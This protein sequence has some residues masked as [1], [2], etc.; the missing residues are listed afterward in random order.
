[1]YEQYNPQE[2]STYANNK[3]A[4]DSISKRYMKIYSQILDKNLSED[5]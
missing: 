3:F 1:M 4:V 2:I 5:T